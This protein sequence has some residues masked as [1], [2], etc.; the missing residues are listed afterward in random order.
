TKGPMDQ[1]QVL[2]IVGATALAL[3]AIHKEGVVHRDLKP[4]NILLPRAGGLKVVDFGIAG[5][6]GAQEALSVGTVRYMAPELFAEGGLDG[7][8]DIYSLGIIA[9]EMLAGREKF[10][11]A[12]RVVIRD[13]RNQAM[14]W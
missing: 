12:F 11:E 5:L 1:K 2:G 6:V 4:S 8:A 14:R 10:N 7:R 13:Q 3:E 9:Y